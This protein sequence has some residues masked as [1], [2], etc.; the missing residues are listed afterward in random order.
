MSKQG[1]S[2]K[3]SKIRGTPG[4]LKK[5]VYER[6]HLTAARTER[7]QRKDRPYSEPRTNRGRYKEEVLMT[8]KTRDLLFTLAMIISMVM[9]AVPAMA[10]FP[11]K[12]G[13]IAFVFGPDIYT[14]NPDGSKLRQLTNLGPE[15]SASWESWS[16]DGKHIVFSE[17]P[18]PDFNGQ[19]W[20]MNADG[21]NQ[22]LLLAEPGITEERPSFSPDGERVIFSRGYEFLP[23]TGRPLI[24]QLYRINV[25]GGGLTQITKHTTLGVHDFGPRY[26][27]DGKTIFFQG[28][29]HGGVLDAVYA[30][31]ANGSGS[32]WE[33]T[34]P[35]I[36]GR[37]HD[38]SPDGMRIT[39]QTHCC[40]PQNETIAVV[41]ADG[42]RLR[43]LTHNG[44]NYDAGP[45]D[46]NPSWSP[47]G[48]KIV[49]ERWTPDFSSSDIFVMKVDGSGLTRHITL[50]ASRVPVGRF[51]PTRE[52]AFEKRKRSSR[53]R[54]IE[55]GG[56]LPRW[57]PAAN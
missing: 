31:D 21:R 15:N 6:R 56:S 37:R 45:H 27:P 38:V 25:D 43:E 46:L 33:I 28:D 42:G 18:P 7:R 53:P 40:N 44:N 41:D 17:F 34:S 11:G 3:D 1:G 48:D 30:I 39:F 4:C 19:L 50:P 23:E 54:E 22:H 14:M 8:P 36:S 49:F 57:G 52:G 24:V 20:I 35:E 47:E 32:E 5:Q 26:S 51:G 29:E 12:N 10:A 55:E 2:K 16:P 9:A 13:R